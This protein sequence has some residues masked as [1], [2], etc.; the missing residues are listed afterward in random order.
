MRLAGSRGEQVR[1]GEHLQLAL[2]V[3]GGVRVAQQLAHCRLV[4]RVRCGAALLHHPAA[5][6]HR[7]HLPHRRCS[8][9]H[10]TRLVEQGRRVP[11]AIVSIA[12]RVGTSL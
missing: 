5:R 12:A 10:S 1:C 7:R 3:A 6:R 8:R 4:D 11:A 9:L 2:D